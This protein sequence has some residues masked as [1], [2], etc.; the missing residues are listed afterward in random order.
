[1][2]TSHSKEMPKTNLTDHYHGKARHV[3]PNQRETKFTEFKEK[4]TGK[5]QT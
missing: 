4:S 1:M 2:L 3:D 5:C